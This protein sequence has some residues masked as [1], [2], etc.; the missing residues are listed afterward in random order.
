[1]SKNF[2][3]EPFCAVCQKVSGSEKVYGRERGEY[4]NFPRKNFRLTVPKILVGEPLSVSLIPGIGKV[5]ASY[6]HVKVFR[7]FFLSR[8]SGKLSRGTLCAV[9]Q[10]VYGSQKSLRIRGG[11]LGFC[12]GKSLSY[13]CEKFRR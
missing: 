9:F 1:M 6:G 7:R 8:S 2:V 4:Q 10:K 12:V 11:V 3:G 13:S 5:F